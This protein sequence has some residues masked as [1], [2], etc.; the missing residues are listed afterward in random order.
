M[1]DRVTPVRRRIDV[2]ALAAF[3]PLVALT[4][5]WLAVVFL[6]WLPLGAVGDV[7]FVLFATSMLALGVVLFSRPVQRLV[8]VR[9]LGARAPRDDELARLRPA[10]V[11]VAQANHLPADRFV[12]A[13]VDGDDVNAF[14]CGGHLLIVSSFAVEHLDDDELL[15][16]LAHELSHHLGGHTVALTVAQ[17]MSLPVLGYARVGLALG[18]VARRTTE[19]L[20][21]R[22]P[23]LRALGLLVSGVLIAVGTVLQIALSSA[24]W[25]SGLVGRGAEYRADARAHEMGFGTELVAA[26]RRAMHDRPDR[27]GWFAA[28]SHPPARLRVARLEAMTRRSRPGR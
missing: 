17:W 20:G 26:L 10:W 4:P 18:G 22:L 25:L 1:N 21:D 3:A 13:V 12:L 8:F 6:T 27:S 9:L 28:L 7:S 14:A 11:T 2:A 16:V 5:P 23:I 24:Q 15:G 19:R